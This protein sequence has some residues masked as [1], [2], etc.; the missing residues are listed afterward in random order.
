MIFKSL[1]YRV[2]KTPPSND[3][4]DV[5]F[6]T[7]CGEVGYGFMPKKGDRKGK[8]CLVR[9]PECHKENYYA[10]VLNGVCAWCSFDVKTVVDKVK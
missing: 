8:I 4:D 5:R 1:C 7:P 3:S 10:S 6:V 2:Y 9:C